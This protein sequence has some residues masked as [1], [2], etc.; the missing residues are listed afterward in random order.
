VDIGG[1]G[2]DISS[3]GFFG[4]GFKSRQTGQGKYRFLF[5]GNLAINTSRHVSQNE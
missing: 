2:S 3:S 1:G 4:T 5:P